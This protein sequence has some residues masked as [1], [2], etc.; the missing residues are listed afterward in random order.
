M[1][2]LERILRWAAGF[3][4]ALIFVLVLRHGTERT[5]TECRTISVWTHP[6]EFTTVRVQVCQP[7]TETEEVQDDHDAE[8]TR[9]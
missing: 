9:R 1:F 7:S 4:A 5:P 2:D 8:D 6:D 3:V